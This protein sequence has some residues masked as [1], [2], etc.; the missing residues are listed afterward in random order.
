ML[1]V[2][3]GFALLAAGILLLIPLPEVGL[4]ALAF[5]LRLLGR[6]YAW[7]RAAN[8]RLDRSVRAG[9]RQWTRL[10]R[11]A[12]LAILILLAAGVVLLVYFLVT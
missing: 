5:G 10:P 2:W 12:Q 3:A 4:P 11:P 6:R 7:A 9:R 8:D 1:T